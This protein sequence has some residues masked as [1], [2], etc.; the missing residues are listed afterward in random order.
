MACLGL[1]PTCP[2]SPAAAATLVIPVIGVPIRWHVG[3]SGRSTPTGLTAAL[4]RGI[5]HKECNS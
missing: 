4:R 2:A 3:S 1:D 5:W